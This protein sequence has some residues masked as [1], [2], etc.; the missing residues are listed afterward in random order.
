MRIYTRSGDDGTTG[1]F[2]GGRVGKDDPRVRA[3]GAV[4]ETNAH[5]GAA[6]AALPNDAELDALLARLQH[7]LFTVGADLATPLDAAARTHLTPVTDAHVTELER[8]IDEWD[9]QSPPLTAFVLPGGHP[10][11]AALHV[12]RA[13]VRRAERDTVA[14]A[15]DED[16]NPAAARWL[17]RC[18]DLLFVVARAAN[19]RTRTA[20]T[21]W[22]PSEDDRAG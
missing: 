5:L 19:V 14:A 3:Y 18:S 13:V 11:A 6:R 21:R 7:A 16:L 20:E 12:A 8:A 9:A 1:L 10:A 15:R 4:D 17:N 2:G 22:D